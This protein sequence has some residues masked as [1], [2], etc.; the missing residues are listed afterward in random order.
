MRIE[1]VTQDDPLYILPLF[2]EF[3]KTYSGRFTIARISSCPTMG[4]RSRQKMIRELSE[5]YGGFG[6][7]RLA[8]R[9]VLSR[10]LGIV[11]LGPAADRFFSLKQLCRAFGV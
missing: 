7:A 5:L 3:F 8:A 11:K 1:F 9:V 6:F 10:L 2:E 4:S